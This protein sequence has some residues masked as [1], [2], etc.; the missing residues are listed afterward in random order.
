MRFNLSSCCGEPGRAS[1][2]VARSRGR[3]QGP[4]LLQ[5]ADE[6]CRLH[7]FLHRVVQGAAPQREMGTDPARLPRAPRHRGGA[8]GP[9]GVGGMLGRGRGRIRL[10]PGP[11]CEQP[12]GH[13]RPAC[14]WGPSPSLPVAGP[15]PQPFVH[16]QPQH[17]QEEPSPTG[18]IQPAVPQR[19][20]RLPGQSRL[21][22][23]GYPDPAPSAAC[24]T[25][26][27]GTRWAR[28]WR[29]SHC[30]RHGAWPGSG[31]AARCEG[32]G[33]GGHRRTPA[34]PCPPPVM[35]SAASVTDM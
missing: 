2:V 34:H 11:G 28:A 21:G 6:L 12:M 16:P 24:G 1:C 13:P 19:L 31:T 18:R 23:E 22:M 27:I 17:R 14:S 26:G 8:P 10:P 29:S 20:P 30:L 32:Q 4:C 5:R 33:L 7:H 25:A 35:V 3:L 15:R 9:S